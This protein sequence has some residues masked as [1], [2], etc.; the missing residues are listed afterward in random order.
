MPTPLRPIH[1]AR[2]GTMNESKGVEG[3][4]Q[5]TVDMSFTPARP[6]PQSAAEAAGATDAQAIDLP[7]EAPSVELLRYYKRRIEEFEAERELFLTRFQE[8][9]VCARVAL[10]AGAA[11][12][13]RGPSAGDT[14]VCAWVRVTAVQVSH[15]ELHRVKWEL[16]V[17]EEEVRRAAAHLDPC[18]HTPPPWSAVLLL[19]P[20]CAHATSVVVVGCG[21]APDNNTLRCAPLHHAARPRSTSCRRR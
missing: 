10:R 9:Q 2:T 21:R 4:P 11:M 19:A 6:A 8:V 16:K 18:A 15:E 17:R 14:P 3:R 5:R 7:T 1:A 12:C 13:G 20:T